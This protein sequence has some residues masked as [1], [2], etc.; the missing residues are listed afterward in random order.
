MPARLLPKTYWVVCSRV[1]DL[2]HQKCAKWTLTLRET[3]T[4]RNPVVKYF[5]YY[6]PA[7]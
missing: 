3:S 7:N 2:A 4:H 6:V 1:G 5:T